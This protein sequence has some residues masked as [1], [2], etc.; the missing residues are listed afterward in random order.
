MKL[1]LKYQDFPPYNQHMSNEH[2]I[3]I[4][5]SAIERIKA[6]RE[7]GTPSFGK[8]DN[9]RVI[10]EGG[11]CSGFQYKMEASGETNDDDIIFDNS[12]II[13]EVS[14]QFLKNSTIKFQN[15]LMGAMFVVDNPNAISSCGCQTSFSIDPSKL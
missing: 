12:V 6:L 3:I 13:D 7:A 2:N 4:D 8:N 1:R 14:L 15:D 11:G 5:P 10:V 9:L